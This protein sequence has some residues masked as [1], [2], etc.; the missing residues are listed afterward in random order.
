VVKYD[1]VKTVLLVLA[2]IIGSIL[3]W[4][5]AKSNNP[6]V[7]KIAKTIQKEAPIPHIVAQKTEKKYLFVPYWSFSKSIVADDNNSLVYFGA[8]VNA[9]GIETGDK[10]YSGI[11]SFIKLT[12]NAQERVLAIR[13][14]DKTINSEIIKNP[15]LQDKIASESV[16]LAIKNKFD[17]V[18]LDY[19]TSAFGFEST[20]NNISSFYR[21]FAKKAH[22]SSLK[23]YVSLYGDTYFQSRPFDTKE[24]GKVA[25]KVLI[26]AYDFSKSGGNPGPDFPL[27]GREKYGY[28][29]GKMVDD[30]Q[31]DVENE[32]IVII[33]GYFGY[34]W[35]VDEK[36]NAVSSG[37]PLSTLEI[38][39][40]FIDK[41]NYKLC[42]M[43]RVPDSLEPYINYQD[44]GGA[45]HIIWFEDE[46]SIDKKK[47]FLKGKGILEN[48]AWAYS[49]F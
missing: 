35:R 20:T 32:K 38:T 47:E 39:K 21:L 24:I 11:A 23:F 10:G 29:F 7:Q 18:L 44:D 27:N 14:T 37:V 6:T 3:L 4:N 22:D 41:C 19:E 2:V 28:D 16:A 15:L 9:N 30:F 42:K 49:Y 48:A 43:N 36:G 46:K 25:D 5:Y 17:G 45:N 31:K 34:D 8:G 26:M 1:K 33:L 13:M 40:E 12:P